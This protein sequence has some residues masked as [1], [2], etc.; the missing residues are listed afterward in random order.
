MCEDT[1]LNVKGVVVI[2]VVIT[3]ILVV[4]LLPV[5]SSIQPAPITDITEVKDSTE[6]G[7]NPQVET[8]TIS[9]SVEVQKAAEGENYYTDEDG[10][11]HYSISVEDSPDIGG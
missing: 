5:K 10:K 2:A 1:N 9:D 6:I 11:K 4:V 8:P 3:V 7:I